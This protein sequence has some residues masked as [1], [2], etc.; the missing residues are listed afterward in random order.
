MTVRS[1]LPHGALVWW[2]AG[3]LFLALSV[4]AL[5]VGPR[6]S[7]FEPRTRPDTDAISPEMV[8]AG[9]RVFHGQGSCFA[10]HGSSLE[11]GPIAPTLKPHAWKDAKGG[12]LATIYSVIVRGVSGTAMVA[13][14]G[15]ISD[16]DATNIAAYIWSVDHRGATP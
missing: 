15:G 5:A 2:V 13:H 10:C 12:E 1:D 14:P 3:L 7:R 6:A 8:S 4:A 9:R 16:A 11:G